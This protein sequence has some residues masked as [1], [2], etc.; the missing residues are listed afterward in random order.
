M[1]LPAGGITFFFVVAQTGGLTIDPL[2]KK[3]KIQFI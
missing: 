3:K 1:Y 2:K